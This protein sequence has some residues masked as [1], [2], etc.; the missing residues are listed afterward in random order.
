MLPESNTCNPQPMSY[1]CNLSATRV[2][3]LPNLAMSYMT[4]IF[5]RFELKIYSDW[6]SSVGEVSELNLDLP[7]LTRNDE[8]KLISVNFDPQVC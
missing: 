7:L 8:S 1:K 5:T 3:V 2:Q 6:T 4:D